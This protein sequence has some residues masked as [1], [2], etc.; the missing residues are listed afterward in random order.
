MIWRSIQYDFQESSLLLLAII[1]IAWAF[2]SLFRYRQRALAT[3]ADPAVL[4]AISVKRNP[5]AFAIKSILFGVIW[6]CATLAL[7]QP[8][9]N[10]RYAGHTD[11]SKTTLQSE[12]RPPMQDVI[13][14]VDASASMRVGDGYR[15]R[16]RL[17]D[18]KEMADQI[19]SRLQHE[20]IS[21]Y[22]FTS[23]LIQIVP[24]TKDYF[25]TR[26]MLRSLE[27]N[28]GETSGTDFEVALSGIGKALAEKPLEMP[29]T[30]IF[31]SDG[32]DTLYEA[33]E[34]EE[35]KSRLNAILQPLQ[36]YPQRHAKIFS[37]GT[38]TK[39][40]GVIPGI[41]YQGNQVISA[42]DASLLEKISALSEG[43]YLSV[44]SKTSAQLADALIEAIKDHAKD[45]IRTS[46]GKNEHALEERA[47][48]IYDIYYQIPLGIAI[49]AFI[50]MLAIPDT[51]I[52]RIK[53]GASSLL[54]LVI[55]NTFIGELSSSLREAEIYFEAGEYAP[56]RSLYELQIDNDMPPWEKAILNYNIGT[57]LLAEQQYAEALSR[58]E[59]ALEGAQNLPLFEQRLSLQIALAKTMIAKEDLNNLQNSGIKSIGRFHKIKKAMHEVSRAIITAQEAACAL[60][61]A[62][63]APQCNPSLQLE[64][65]GSENKQLAALYSKLYAQIYSN[66]I[67]Q[68]ADS[69][70][71]LSSQESLDINARA[72]FLKASIDYYTLELGLMPLQ[73]ENIAALLKIESGAAKF[74]SD[75]KQKASTELYR[76]SLM[77]TTKALQ[78]LNSGNEEETEFYLELA[79]YQ[80]MKMRF[81]EMP[82]RTIHSQEVLEWA[83]AQQRVAAAL[84]QLALA[85]NGSKSTSNAEEKS[86]LL[87]IIAL[88]QSEAID[89]GKQ[90][91]TVA[92]DDQKESF[93][94]SNEDKENEAMK[95]KTNRAIPW[96]EVIPLVMDG[97]ELAVHAHH[98][99][100]N[101][102]LTSALQDQKKAADKWE[103]ALELM[104]KGRGSGAS[105]ESESKSESE[106]ISNENN[107]RLPDVT[108][109]DDEMAEILQLIQEM[110]M[111]DNSRSELK[112]SPATKDQ[113]RPW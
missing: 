26:L 40:G 27:I 76:N 31:L 93:G 70:R 91:L 83:L 7:M 50:V 109:K 92:R 34:G 56:A 74:F 97:S 86:P 16:M 111:D 9:G 62:E 18:A 102:N 2:T 108:V 100:P 54:L 24:P 59:S 68:T 101:E 19:I 11:Q 64:K 55:L 82:K 61:K 23:S 90:F 12:R 88:I 37:V 66:A 28:E 35:K 33:K 75:D 113:D 81:L 65:I 22:A 14:L 84:N 32:G 44:E 43:K 89:S 98:D 51:V 105:S 17:D 52:R 79:R 21:L 47:A 69:I 4:Q 96:D 15:G 49:F 63:G 41:A 30:L 110:E 3:F 112:T 38:G 85:I 48:M 67:A 58:F 57:V 104:R 77:Y 94:T 29:K 13:L 46:G 106:E 107:M 53:K 99:L 78:F 20:N 6:I 25:F 42:L 5:L 80:L 8:K 71:Q 36:N 95:Q 1:I 103:R 39:A 10:V 87:P 45:Y 60:Q 73:K 72:Q